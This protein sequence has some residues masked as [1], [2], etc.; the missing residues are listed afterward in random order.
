[1]GKSL[2]L[3]LILM[4]IILGIFLIVPVVLTSQVE[5]E[6]TKIIK[7]PKALVFEQI[8]NLKNRAQWTPFEKTPNVRDSLSAPETGIGAKYYWMS[9]DTIKRVLTITKMKA[10]DFVN[11]ELWFPNN[12]GATEKWV[13]TG[14]STKT[15]V[16]WHFTVLNLKYPFGKWLGLVLH[17]SLGTVLKEGLNKLNNACTKENTEAR[18]EPNQ[19]I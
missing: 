3:T 10:P 9:G 13:L 5:I 14:D 1:M 11:M 17:N 6:A 7:A 15:L 19:P 4:G 18:K 16:S 12:H 2:K 8:S